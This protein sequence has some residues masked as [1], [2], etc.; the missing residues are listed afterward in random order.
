MPFSTLNAPV[1]ARSTQTV[2]VRVQPFLIDFF[3]FP[4]PPEMSA[5]TRNSLSCV[6]PASF[7]QVSGV[8]PV[9][10]TLVSAVVPVPFHVM[11]PDPVPSAA[12]G[13]VPLPPVLAVSVQPL[14]FPVVPVKELPEIFL[15]TT[16]VLRRCRR[17]SSCQAHRKK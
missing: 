5:V 8:T 10:V 4:V 17:R 9:G 12:I 1:P 15:Q 3:A 13:N 7:G 2:E 14:S 16:L 6:P 11:F